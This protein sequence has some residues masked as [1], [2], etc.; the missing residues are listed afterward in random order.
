MPYKPKL[1]GETDVSSFETTFTRERPVDSNPDA[2]GG[3]GTKRKS[4]EE[5][6]EGVALLFYRDV[7][8]L[9]VMLYCVSVRMCVSGVFE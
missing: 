5:D 8:L 4:G 7:T 9:L 1:V 2:D 3:D 6:F